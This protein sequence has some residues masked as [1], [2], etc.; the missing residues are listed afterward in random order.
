MVCFFYRTSGNLREKHMNTLPQSIQQ[1]VQE[2]LFALQQLVKTNLNHWKVFL[3]SY[4][5]REMRSQFSWENYRINYWQQKNLGKHSKVLK[6][7]RL[8]SN[9][10]YLDFSIRRYWTQI[11]ILWVTIMYKNAII[12]LNIAMKIRMIHKKIF[13]S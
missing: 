5:K 10:H 6:L 12:Q 2:D 3:K 11:M 8:P 1:I 4:L 13:F 7:A 9:V